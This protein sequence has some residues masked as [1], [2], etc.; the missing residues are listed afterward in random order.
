MSVQSIP[1]VGMTSGERSAEVRHDLAKRVRLLRLAQAMSQERLANEAGIDRSTV[2]R[3]ENA[4]KGV[5]LDSLVAIADT[6]GVPL[7]DLFHNGNDHPTGCAS[8]A[9]EPTGPAD[10]AHAEPHPDRS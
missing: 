6:L 8:H 1:W 9:P 5:H 3:L 4:A 2:S 10:Q 7:A